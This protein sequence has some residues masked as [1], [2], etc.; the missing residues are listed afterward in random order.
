MPFLAT[1]WSSTRQHFLKF[2]ARLAPVLGAAVGLL[3]RLPE[4]LLQ[5]LIALAE[6]TAEPHTR[7]GIRALLNRNGVRNNFRLAYHEFR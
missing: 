2:A 6:P 5:G 1:D 3:N 4:R 7:E